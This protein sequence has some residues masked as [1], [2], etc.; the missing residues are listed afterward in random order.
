MPGPDPEGLDIE[1]LE[2]GGFR[3]YAEVWST[4]T[5]GTGL[6][7]C[8]PL[9]ATFG[10]VAGGAGDAVSRCRFTS[11]P[12]RASVLSGAGRYR[13]EFGDRGDERTCGIRVVRRCH[14]GQ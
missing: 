2:N 9:R 4:G 10:S 14:A 6:L 13:R 5:S 11:E 12:M 1:V 8:W 7:G 3:I